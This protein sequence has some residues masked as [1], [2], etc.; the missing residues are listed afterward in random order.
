VRKLS[1]AT[2]VYRAMK[3]L[4]ALALVVAAATTAHA[5]YTESAGQSKPKLQVASDEHGNAKGNQYDLAIDGA[6]KGQTIAVI[7]LYNFDFSSAAKALGEKG[8]N[9]VRWTAMP[10]AKVLDEALAKSTQLWIIA[11]SS[12]TLTDDHVAVIKRFWEAGHGLYIWGDNNP[13]Y[14][15]ANV[16]GKALFK[17]TMEGDTLGDK[18]V[19]IQSEPGKPGLVPNLLLTTGLE[20]LY[21]GITIAT[22]H[23]S[24]ELRPFLVGSAGNVVAAYYERD[25]RRAIF[26]GGFT[27]LYNKWDTAGTARYVK[28]AAAWLVN[29]E[30]FKPAVAK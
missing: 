6:F 29:V 26:D 27:R 30:R 3:I 19:D 20:H 11:S 22:I 23:P 16:L 2:C 15:D 21:E 13:Y 9:V 17:T 1:G 18:P 14:A 5:Q 28:N 25:G 10:S 4:A 12:V 8:F 7:Q 24:K